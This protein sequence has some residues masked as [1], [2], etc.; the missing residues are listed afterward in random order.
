VV[1]LRWWDDRPAE[2]HALDEAGW[3]ALVDLVLGEH[4]GGMG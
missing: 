3:N 1:R 2:L 4:C